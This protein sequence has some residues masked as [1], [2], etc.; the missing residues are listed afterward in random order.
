MKAGDIVKYAVP[1]DG[2][3]SFR[4]M[5]LEHNGDRVHIAWIEADGKPL[6]WPITPCE[7]VHPFDLV[8]A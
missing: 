8:L 2:E 3:Q 7:T 6:Y 4:F 5:V 1:Q